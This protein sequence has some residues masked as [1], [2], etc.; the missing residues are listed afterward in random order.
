ML[1]A[2]TYN[3]QLLL[4]GLFV[5]ANLLVHGLLGVTAEH[6]RDYTAQQAQ[7]QQSK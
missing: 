3:Y 2:P 5:T 7:A 1:Q 6:Y 4:L